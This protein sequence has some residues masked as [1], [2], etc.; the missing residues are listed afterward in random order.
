MFDDPYA[1][2]CYAALLASQLDRVIY[3]DLDTMFTA[4]LRSG[5]VHAKNIDVYLPSEGRLV[6]MI[7]DV[8]GSMESSSL[9]VFDS[10]NSFYNMFTTQEMNTSGLNHML[11]VLLMLLLRRGVD[12]NVPVLVTSMM[13]YRKEGGWVQSP[14]SRRLLQRKSAVKIS[15]ERVGYDLTVKIMEHE[16]EPPGT[17]FVIKNGAVV[18]I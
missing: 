4:Y 15:V 8:L 7:K 6:P 5:F 13:R 10:V 17:A 12:A 3:F 16:S 14:S 9:V 1:K 18:T 2:L 11:S